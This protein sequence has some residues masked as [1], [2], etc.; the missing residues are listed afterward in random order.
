MCY[1]LLQ[2]LIAAEYSMKIRKLI[3]KIKISGKS[4]QYPT[5]PHFKSFKLEISGNNNLIS[6]END[7]DIK[8]C[9][10]KITGDNNRIHIGANTRFHAHIIIKGNN[11]NLQ[12]GEG[13]LI[14]KGCG[15][16]YGHPLLPV[17]NASIKIGNTTGMNGA[18]LFAY[19]NNSS[20]IIGDNCMF[21]A[22]IVIYNTTTHA[23]IDLNSNKVRLGKTLEIGNRVWVATDVKIGRNVK[24]PNNCIVSWGSVVNGK[25][26]QE[27]TVIAGNPAKIVKENIDWHPDLPQYYSDQH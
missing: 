26:E 21:A 14:R 5:I 3:N 12:I 10:I 16:N 9:N 1:T 20:I 11:N 6:W 7:V 19:D 25:F 24:I 2:F 18:A 13:C 23:V 22:G 15:F 8:N 27:H 4:N 17:N